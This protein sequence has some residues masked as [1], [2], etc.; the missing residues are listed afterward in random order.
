VE[1]RLV[2]QGVLRRND[3]YTFFLTPISAEKP[4]PISAGNPPPISAEATGRSEG[5]DGGGLGPKADGLGPKADGLGPKADGL[6]PK[7]RGYQTNNFR[8]QV[9]SAPVP[10][11]KDALSKYMKASQPLNG[12]VGQEKAAAPGDQTQM[13][14]FVTSDAWQLAREAARRGGRQ[15]SAALWTGRLMRDTASPEVF[16]LLEA[17]IEAEHAAE[18]EYSILFSGET[19]QRVRERLEMRRRRLNRPNEM[20]LGSV[21]GHNFLPGVDADGRRICGDCSKREVCSR[22]SASLSPQD[23]E[24]H[25]VHFS[26]QPWAVLLVWGWNARD[27]EEWSFYGLSNA[28]LAPRALR[29]LNH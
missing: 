3:V 19:W 4:P 2:A 23:E 12:R 28:A 16:M 14:V 9:R 26:G 7:A 24:W 29:Q 1:S 11:E 25:R 6:G 15:E 13:P 18:T 10:L 5:S 8:A 17:C 20:I 22:T 27:E 21:H